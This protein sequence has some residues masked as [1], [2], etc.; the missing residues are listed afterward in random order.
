MRRAKRGS[1]GVAG[2]LP[3]RV[4]PSVKHDLHETAR[5]W[6]CARRISD[7]TIAAP[8]MLSAL[9]E[10]KASPKAAG[11][12]TKASRAETTKRLAKAL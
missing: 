8:M 2:D 10:A 5:L 3:I 12:I 1:A 6:A 9:L 4:V 11:A 7:A